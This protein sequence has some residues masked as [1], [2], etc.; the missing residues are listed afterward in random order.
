MPARRC[1]N[2]GVDATGSNQAEAAPPLALMHKEGRRPGVVRVLGVALPVVLAAALGGCSRDTTRATES[3]RGAPGGGSGAE[4]V[5]APPFAEVSRELG[6]DFVH[7]TRSERT[8]PMPAIMG[9]GFCVLDADGDD[10]LDLYFIDGGDFG[11]SA[12]AAPGARGHRFYRREADGRY[13]D[14]TDASGLGDAGHGM[15]CASGDVDN[16]GDLDVFVTAWGRDTLYRNA[17]GGRFRDDTSGAGL[18]DEAWSASATFFDYD[19]DGWLDLFVTRYV[20][21]DPRR[22][23]ALEGGRLDYCGPQQFSGVHDLLY[24]NR[25]DGTFEDR[26]RAAG[27]AGVQLRGLGVIAADFDDDGWV[28]VYVAN[29][30]DPNNLWINQGDGT[31]RDD[32]VLLGAAYNRYGVGEAGMGLAAADLGDDGDLD[33]LVTHLIEETNTLYENRGALGFEDVTAASGIGLPSLP[34][35]GF[36]VALFDADLDSDLDVAVANG[37]IKARP[38][39]LGG[40]PDW[41]WNEYAEPNLFLIQQEPGRFADAT[42]RSGAFGRDLDV[43]RGLVAADLEGD[44]DL[45]LVVGNVEGP[46]RIYRNPVQ[47]ERST[48]AAWL[49]VRPWLPERKREAVGAK[50]VTVTTMGRRVGHALPP[51]SYLCGGH[52]RVHLALRE[53]ER[54]EAFE[55]RW[56][57][58]ESE[59][60][61]PPDRGGVVVLE[62][63]AGDAL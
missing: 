7:S 55:V 14:D 6:V 1:E 15:G 39:A 37:A 16:D 19:R 53:G 31:F 3:P 35:T 63:G 42:P 43:S 34:F 38:E 30:S 58:G 44:G 62:R 24:R 48:K 59:R 27:I 40:R 18:G 61:A 60:F 54:V 26:T 21:L 51:T 5:S 32:A 52:A 49:E 45:D 46:A 47:E 50:V 25:G 20:D 23:C 36:G 57:D 9:G 8:Y 11:S 12:G 33:I 41:F 2:A 4:A 10:D 28:D 13:V 56:P 29:D 17:G 22:E